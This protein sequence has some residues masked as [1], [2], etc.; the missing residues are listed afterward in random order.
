MIRPGQFAFRGIAHTHTMCVCSSALTPSSARSALAGPWDRLGQ[1]DTA[2]H[3]SASHSLKHGLADALKYILEWA[4]VVCT[5]IPHLSVQF[6][7]CTVCTLYSLWLM[8]LSALGVGSSCLYCSPSVICT[9]S[10]DFRSFLSALCVASEGPLWPVKHCFI[11]ITSH[12]KKDHGCVQMAIWLIQS[13]AG[14][15]E[16]EPRFG[17]TFGFALYCQGSVSFARFLPSFARFCPFFAP[18]RP[19]SAWKCLFFARFCPVSS[20]F[21]R[22]RSVSFVPCLP[23]FGHLWSGAVW[24]L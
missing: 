23:G 9:V 2:Y 13:G 3:K 22:I 5:A 24:F 16:P 11:L 12:D 20:K 8:L 4:A 1:P 18:F 14:M 6:V 19:V 7:H 21:T 10:T 17:D 15:T